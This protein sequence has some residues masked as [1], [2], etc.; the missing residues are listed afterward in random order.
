MPCGLPQHLEGSQQLIIYFPFAAQVRLRK[1][2]WH[3][4]TKPKK[5]HV[6]SDEFCWVWM[7]L[8]KSVAASFT[9]R[10]QRESGVSLHDE[11]PP[12]PISS[13]S[14]NSSWSLPFSYEHRDYVNCSAERKPRPLSLKI[15]PRARWTSHLLNFIVLEPRFVPVLW[16]IWPTFPLEGLC[17]SLHKAGDMNPS[18]TCGLL[19]YVQVNSNWRRNGSTK[20][21]IELSKWENFIQSKSLIAT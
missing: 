19:V 20:V 18:H 21:R 10:I 7:M 9:R 8:D 4:K 15:L 6:R 5:A 16:F 12:C 2:I 1:C 13:A 14:V 3:W 11:R 17:Y